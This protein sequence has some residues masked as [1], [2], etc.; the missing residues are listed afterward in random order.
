VPEGGGDG[1]IITQGGRFAGYGLFVNKGKPT[2][3]WN[4]VG[5]QHETWEAPEPLSAGKHTVEFAFDYDGL[6]GG[7]LAFNSFSGLGQSGTGTLKVDG[8]VVATKKMEKTIPIILAWDENMDIG[9]D[10]GT[11][12]DDTAYKVPFAFTGTID[13]LKLSIDR[14]TLSDA[15]KAKLEAAMR[16][17]K[18]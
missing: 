6:G 9:S 16:A 10:T 2:F 14:P 1:M 12:V 13:D 5:L 17:T 3:T 11:P 4:L 15:D 8:K 18:D 7:T